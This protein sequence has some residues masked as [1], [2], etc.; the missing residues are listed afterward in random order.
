M[1]KPKR[2]SRKKPVAARIAIPKTRW[3][4]QTAKARFSELFRRAR[5]EG[6]QWITKQDKEAVVMLTAEEYEA[7][8]RP[9][10][11]FFRQAGV[12]ILD[13]NASDQTPQAIFDE[14]RAHLNASGLMESFGK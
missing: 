5:T 7:L 3:Q 12:K 8:T 2:R 13:E 1:P 6:P 14:I 4:L 9:V 11:D 10:I